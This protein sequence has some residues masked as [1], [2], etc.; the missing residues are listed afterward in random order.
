MR[1]FSIL[2]ELTSLV[3][4]CVYVQLPVNGQQVLPKVEAA[5]M[6]GAATM[7][8]IHMEGVALLEMARAIPKLSTLTGKIL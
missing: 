6:P 1:I 4:C 2:R 7:S 8:S 3:T 5:F